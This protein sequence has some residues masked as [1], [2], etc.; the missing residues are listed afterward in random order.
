M[1]RLRKCRFCKEMFGVIG[2]LDAHDNGCCK[3]YCLVRA[4]RVKHAALPRVVEAKKEQRRKLKKRR[5]AQKDAFFQ[6]REWLELRY[7]TLK[8]YGRQCMLCR[9]D[10]GSLHVDH[11]EPRSKRPDLALN[12]NNLQVLC[13]L[14]NLGKSNRDNTDFRAC[15]APTVEVTC[16]DAAQ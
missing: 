16:E 8:K 10:R 1:K 12:P 14:C 11:I 6:S 3:D 13:R 4:G 5:K 7:D 9:T 15:Q 2:G